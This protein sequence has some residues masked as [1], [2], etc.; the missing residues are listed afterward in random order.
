[1]SRDGFIR[2]KTS[3]R[4]ARPPYFRLMEKVNLQA[5]RPFDDLPVPWLSPKDFA[6]RCRDGIVIDTRDVEAFAGGHIP[7]SYSVWLNGTGQYGG[8]VTEELTRV[9]LVADSP[10]AV[11]QA[12]LSLARIGRDS[13]MGALRG[14]FEAWR[15]AGLPIAMAGTLSPERLLAEAGRI[16][17]LDVRE[18]G[19]FEEEGHI[20]NARHIHAGDLEPQIGLLDLS[21]DQPIAVTCS[22]GHRGSLGV[23]I[24][25][26]H[27][28]SNVFNLLGGMTA[29]K[30]RGLP[31]D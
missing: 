9:Y 3:E 8:W 27:G 15:D 1:M 2:H 14:G 26:R 25:Q 18:I 5:G 19:E 4:M 10:S 13:V 17:V 24:L 11:R 30:N 16:A 22:V 21:K 20:P 31:M 23:S 7:D 12:R 28:Y 29:W 6:S